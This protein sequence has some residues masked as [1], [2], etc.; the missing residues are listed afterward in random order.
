MHNLL[1][2]P[3]VQRRVAV[4]VCRGGPLSALQFMPRALSLQ[5]YGP[6]VGRSARGAQVRGIY[7]PSAVKE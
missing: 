3:R 4:Y 5:A 2:H 1:A 7:R 6:P